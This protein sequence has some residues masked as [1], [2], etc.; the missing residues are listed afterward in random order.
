[1]PD[2]SI[3]LGLNANEMYGELKSAEQRLSGSMDRMVQSA[4]SLTGA[5]ENLLRSNHRVATQIHAVTRDFLSGASGADVFA[6]S[7][8]GIGRSLNIGLGTLAGLAI[9]AVVFQQISKATGEAEKLHNEIV[10]ITQAGAGDPRF[11]TLDALN[12]QLEESKKNIE[13]LKDETTGVSF[14]RF[15]QYLGSAHLLGG[16]G[17]DAQ[18]A[19]EG[20]DKSRLKR[21]ESGAYEGLAS[22]TR[23]ST[24]IEGMSSDG[25][26]ADAQRAKAQMEFRVAYNKS[27]D[28]AA[29]GSLGAALGEA[30]AAKLTQI[31]HQQESKINERSG[32][33]VAELANMVP[34]V[35]GMGTVSYEKWQASHTARESQAATAEG[36]A[37]RLSMNREGANAGFNHA[38]D[39]N[40]G[41][42]AL[43]P[44]EQANKDLSAAVGISNGYLKIIADKVGGRMV[45]R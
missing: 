13:K 30:F 25:D 16:H 10:K 39:I 45:N 31:T 3:S 4:N 40:A 35:G 20:E 26:S 7:L 18:L 28:S 24:R 32:M 23:E 43:K 41:L 15:F 36:E 42:P 27:L 33:T 9:G 11:R 34:E 17:W 44:S 12:T 21:S 2:A 1:M 14:T 29:G 5:H 22:K 6:A 38:S 19:Q 8:D 37:A